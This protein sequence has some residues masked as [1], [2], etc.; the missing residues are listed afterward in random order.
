MLVR[1][2]ALMME[3]ASTFGTL[4]NFYENT[5][6]NIP[7]DCHCCVCR[8]ENVK[9]YFNIFFNLYYDLKFAVTVFFKYNALYLCV[10][11]IVCWPEEVGHQLT[12]DE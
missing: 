6:Y 1:F 10:N 2:A 8:C 7:E 3:V 5:Q 12:Y 4:A 9:S 11:I